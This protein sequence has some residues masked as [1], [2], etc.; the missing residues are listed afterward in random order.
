MI[1]VPLSRLIKIW[2]RVKSWTSTTTPPRSVTKK[3][4][5][6][7]RPTHDFIWIELNWLV[8]KRGQPQV[9]W[10]SPCQLQKF[11][12]AKYKKIAERKNKERTQ[13]RCVDWSPLLVDWI[14]SHK[15]GPVPLGPFFLVVSLCV[16]IKAETKKE[17]ATAAGFC[18]TCPSWPICGRKGNAEKKR[19]PRVSQGLIHWGWAPGQL[20]KASERL[21]QMTSCSKALGFALFR[22]HENQRLDLKRCHQTRGVVSSHIFRLD[23]SFW[24]RREPMRKP[25]RIHQEV[26]LPVQFSRVQKWNSMSGM[27]W[28]PR[29]CC[30][31]IQFATCCRFHL[32]PWTTYG[33][34][35]WLCSSFACNMRLRWWWLP[36]R[37]PWRLS[38]WISAFF[39]CGS[40]PWPCGARYGWYGRLSRNAW[41]HG[42][43]S[44]LWSQ[45]AQWNHERS[46]AHEGA[47]ATVRK[48]HCW[49]LK[50][51]SKDRP[52][53]T[54]EQ[55]GDVYHHNPPYIYIL[56]I[57][58][59]HYTI[60]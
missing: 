28:S 53:M 54:C 2:Q 18:C 60:I 3:C 49:K 34:G 51:G 17:Q 55:T 30:N 6:I 26:Q 16:R 52:P 21:N 19:C 35:S 48:Q 10:F 33:F 56:Y 43:A 25:R 41:W 7:H 23:K 58:T 14:P 31:L 22:L 59:I 38:R 45:Y 12:D 29:Y 1:F 37:L 5:E 44:W 32:F 46:R 39:F 57:N 9:C 4:Q 42:N 40:M 8:L 15:T 13:F 24:R 27:H 47:R 20:Q 11:V 36:R 50:S